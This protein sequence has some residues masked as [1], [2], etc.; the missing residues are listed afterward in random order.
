MKQEKK[1]ATGYDKYIDWK[2]FSLPVVLLAAILPYPAP[3]EHVHDDATLEEGVHQL[4]VG[5]HQSLLVM[6]GDEI[7]GGAP[8][9]CFHAGLRSDQD[10]GERR[11][12]MT[13]GP[14]GSGRQG[15]AGFP[16]GG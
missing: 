15:G 10:E 9:R 8:D 6:K 12:K 7:V 13:G 5:K 4:I 11:L 14:R 3:G 2:M 16:E 1:K